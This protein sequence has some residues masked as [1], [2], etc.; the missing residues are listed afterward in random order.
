M[1][2]YV[3]SDHA[4]VELRE[5]L[6]VV[7]TEAGWEIAA[8]F[9]PAR[10]DTRA[11][12]PDVAR[13]LCGAL[14]ADEGAFGLLVCGT[15]QGMAMTANRQAGVRA[16]VCADTFSAQMARA[17]ND[18]QVLCLGQR[19]VGVGLAEQILRAFLAGSFEGGRHA[20]RVAKIGAA[21]G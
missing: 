21:G 12:Y 15:G 11:D 6:A 9:G 1:R 10:A 17:H 19:V 3:G 20:R 16:A 13:A 14:S 5:A 2:L 8:S 4:G 18:A 7:A